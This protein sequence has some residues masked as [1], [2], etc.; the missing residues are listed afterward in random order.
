[1]KASTITPDTLRLGRRLPVDDIGERETE[2]A[3][4]PGIVQRT[5]QPYVAIRA[6]VTMQTFG[7]VVPGLHPEVRRWLRT[8]GVPPAGQPFCKYNVIDMDR[9]LEVEAGFPVAA[10]VT[11]EGRVL[12][13]VL[14]AGRYA[15]LW[16]T[17]HPDGLI[18]AVQTLRDWAAQQ[19]LAWDVTSTPDGE[20]WGCRLE[21]YHDEPGQDMSE[22]KTGLAFKLAD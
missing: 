18:G 14:P 17:G 19:G 22:W 16:Y 3:A 6:F 9:Q 15:T 13:A 2:M 20:R 8:Q 10:Q 1:V 4:E 5:E 12:A 7:E 21:F 11:G